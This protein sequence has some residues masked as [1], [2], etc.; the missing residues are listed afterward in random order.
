MFEWRSI[1][2]FFGILLC[3]PVLHLA[4]QVADDFQAYL[5][6]SPET[7]AEDMN[8]IVE[9]DETL[10]LPANPVLVVGGRRVS[11]WQDLPAMLAPHPTLLRGLGDATVED[12]THY[13]D[14]LIGFYRPDIVVLLPSYADLH[15]RD[16]KTAGELLEAV[17]ELV[18]LNRQHL[19]SAKVCV[20]APVKTPLHPG[21]DARI[22]AMSSALGAWA[23][24][25]S[26]VI[27]IDANPLL[28]AA[29]GRPDPALYRGD[30][31]NLNEQGYLRLAMVLRETLGSS[32]KL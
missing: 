30:G 22:D 20:I 26:G 24:T 28:A 29:D 32:S 9:A 6:P 11:L 21:D 5:D 10:P 31:V 19:A 4:W 18:D 15:L 23:A 13:Y 17:R 8:A 7:W 1:R 25:E 27:A 12:I 16:N 14:R 3:L 2:M